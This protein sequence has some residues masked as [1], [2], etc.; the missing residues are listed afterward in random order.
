MPWTGERVRSSGRSG[1]TQGR[2]L[3]LWEGLLHGGQHHS[4]AAPWSLGGQAPHAVPVWEGGEEWSQLLGG[5][6]LGPRTPQN[7]PPEAA[8][9]LTLSPFSP[10]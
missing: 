9:I 5:L 8:S 3:G 7:P 10:G 4:P 1:W 2:G 6:S